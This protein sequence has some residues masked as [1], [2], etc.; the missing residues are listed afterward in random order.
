MT[1]I[2]SL[3]TAPTAE[4]LDVVVAPDRIL[5]GAPTFRRWELDSARDGQVRTGIFSGSEGSNASIKGE[6][7]EF[8][9]LLEGEI[10]I[11]E[12]G[13]ETHTYRAGD[14]FLLKPGFTGVWKTIKPYRKIY[15]AVA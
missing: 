3:S 15:V 12:T 6:T 1:Q 13:G 7:F 10:E 14:S 8:C 11:T 2:V 4:P 5:D 9:H